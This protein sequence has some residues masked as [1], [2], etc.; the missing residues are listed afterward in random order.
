PT[1]R[2]RSA[3]PARH[4]KAGTVTGIPAGTRIAA[5]PAPPRL[6]NLRAWRSTREA[7]T[8]HG[9]GSPGTNGVENPLQRITSLVNVQAKALSKASAHSPWR[10]FPAARAALRALPSSCPAYALTE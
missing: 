7:E 5:T 8:K 4:T 9:D 2:V 6:L 10:P 3:A 1:T